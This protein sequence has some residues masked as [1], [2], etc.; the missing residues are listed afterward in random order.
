MANA[1]SVDLTG[2]TIASQVQIGRK[3]GAGGMG[4]VYL[5]EQID[6]GRQVVI[7]VMHPELTAGSPT[8]LERFKREARAVATLNHPNIVQVYVFGQTASGQMSF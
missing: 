6:M 8:A 3:L 2:K 7:K 4:A 1:E 5:A